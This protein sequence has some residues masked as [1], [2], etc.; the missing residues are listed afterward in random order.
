MV[1]GRGRRSLTV[2]ISR[3][4]SGSVTAF[5][6]DQKGKEMTNLYFSVQFPMEFGEEI[7]HA[8]MAEIGADW[9]IE[10]NMVL[11]DMIRSV[12]DSVQSE[13]ERTTPGTS[14]WHYDNHKGVNYSAC[15]NEL[16]VKAQ[17]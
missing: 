11:M 2:H 16:C 5:V 15:E 12:K 4:A 6:F 10:T 3:H 9:S 13:I 17:Q 7:Q 8:L 1:Q 14:R